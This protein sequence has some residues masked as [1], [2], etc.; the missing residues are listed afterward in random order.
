MNIV[1]VKLLYIL[2]TVMILHSIVYHVCV[3]LILR[4]YE[5][6][7]VFLVKSGVTKW[8]QSRN[9]CRSQP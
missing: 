8:Y 9:D 2:I 4:T 5:M 1:S 7:S 3:I 6:H